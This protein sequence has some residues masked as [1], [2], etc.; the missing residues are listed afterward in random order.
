MT[1]NSSRNNNTPNASAPGRCFLPLDRGCPPF[2]EKNK[3][4]FL[5][6]LIFKNN[7]QCEYRTMIVRDNLEFDTVNECHMTSSEAAGDVLG[8]N[9]ESLGSRRIALGRAPTDCESSCG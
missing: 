9:N 4:I 6:F 1:V 3:T 5:N 7:N 2:F 8:T